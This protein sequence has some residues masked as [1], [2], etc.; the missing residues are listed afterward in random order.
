MEQI[1]CK[2]SKCK[3][4]H[5]QNKL[6]AHNKELYEFIANSR[7]EFI[8]LTNDEDRLH[9][10]DM[11]I[12][13][14]CSN[15]KV[16][17]AFWLVE[18]TKSVSFLTE[19]KYDPLPVTLPKSKRSDRY[20]VAVNFFHDKDQNL[21]EPVIE[22]F[23]QYPQEELQFPIYAGQYVTKSAAKRKREE[24]E[25][26]LSYGDERTTLFLD[27]RIIKHDLFE[28]VVCTDELKKY[29]DV[30]VYTENRCKRLYGDTLLNYKKTLRS[31][32][33]VGTFPASIAAMKTPSTPSVTFLP[34]K[35]D[36]P[37]SDICSTR[38]YPCRSA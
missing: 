24:L 11:L 33:P 6:D 4:Q 14:F 30:F 31:T 8:E 1:Y 22:T 9:Y 35:A 5:N 28:A 12:D 32:D 3:S 23:F 29:T 34:L 25:K 19:F 17:Q 26:V 2:T 16:E 27:A 21:I 36:T 15:Y 13:K 7:F 38:L 10:A 20:V 18:H 37:M